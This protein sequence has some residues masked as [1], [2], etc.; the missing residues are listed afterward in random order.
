[1]LLYKVT[2]IGILLN[3]EVIIVWLSYLEMYLLISGRVMSEGEPTTGV[4]LLLYSRDVKSVTAQ[5]CDLTDVKKLPAQNGLNALCHTTSGKTGRFEF[6][7][8]PCGQYTI[9]PVY[10]GKDIKFD[11]VPKQLDFQ[12]LC[13]LLTF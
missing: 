5:A 6:G 10:R 13:S 4:Q 8:L 3:L 12:V 2:N 1:M 7:A 9:V 11:L